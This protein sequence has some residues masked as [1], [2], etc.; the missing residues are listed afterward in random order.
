MNDTDYVHRRNFE[1]IKLLG[2]GRATCGFRTRGS[3]HSLSIVSIRK[4]RSGQII[5]TGSYLNVPILNWGGC[6][7]PAEASTMTQ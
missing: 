6:L 5:Q 3:V 2:I 1:L 4:F 7:A